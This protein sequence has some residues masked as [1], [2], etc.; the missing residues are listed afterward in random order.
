MAQFRSWNKRAHLKLIVFGSNGQLAQ[1]IIANENIAKIFSEI[2]CV[3]WRQFLDGYVPRVCSKTVVIDTFAN[4]DVDY[5]ETF[6]ANVIKSHLISHMRLLEISKKAYRYIY[7]S[8]TGVYGDSTFEPHAEN[9]RVAPSTVH[10][11]SKYL[12]EKQAINEF[13]ERSLILRIGWLFSTL[14]LKKNFVSARLS[15]IVSAKRSNSIL[16]VFQNQIGNPTFGP[17]L[18]DT[19]CELIEHDFSGLLNVANPSP[20]SRAEFIMEIANLINAAD[21]I[22]FLPLSERPQRLANVADNEMA[23]TTLL[24]AILG[25][26]LPHWNIGLR[27]SIRSIYGKK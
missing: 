6:P 22:N 23:D 9:D 1:C 2:N 18:V 3:S 5:A 25:R 13:S 8:S 11:M 4:T 19:I 21:V 17:D 24:R 16:N 27:H 15:D 20:V 7:I 26:E 12:A 14:K 10:H